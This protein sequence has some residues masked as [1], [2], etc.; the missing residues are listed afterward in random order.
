M[1]FLKAGTIIILFAS[2]LIFFGRNSIEKYLNSGVIISRD[3][4]NTNIIREH[5]K[6]EINPPTCMSNVICMWKRLIQ[7]PPNI[8]D[9]QS[10]R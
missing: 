10:A 1:H 7:R 4:E 5:F 2:Y 8:F 9:F 3:E 6:R